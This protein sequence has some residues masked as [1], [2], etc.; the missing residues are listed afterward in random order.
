MVGNLRGHTTSQ[1]VVHYNF[2][3][4]LLPYNPVFP[5]TPKYIHILPSIS[6][7]IQKFHGAKKIVCINKFIS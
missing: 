3:F 7:Y 4:H 6:T 2:D 1:L 5:C